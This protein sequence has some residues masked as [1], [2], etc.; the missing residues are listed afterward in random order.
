MTPDVRPDPPSAPA[1][2]QAWSRIAREVIGTAYPWVPGHT[3]TGPDDAHLV[4]EVLHPAFHGSLD[5]HSCVHM[6]WSLLTLLSRYG[7]ALGKEE[8]RAVRGLLG[9]RLRPEQVAVEVDYLRERPGFERPYGWAWAAQLCAA[10][11][12]AGEDDAEVAGWAAATGPLAE[13]V[14]DLVLGWLPRQPYPVR[15]GKHQNDAFALWLL[16]DAFERL[17]RDG[18]VEAC[19]GRSLDWFGD[20]RGAPTGW[21]PGG[22]DFLSPALTEAGLMTRVLPQ[23]R[24][25]PWLE[26]FLPGLGLAGDHDPHRHLLEVPVV[27][28]PTDGQYAHLL[29][30]ALSRA[31]QL[32]ELTPHLDEVR[33]ERLRAAAVEQEAAVLR[34][35]T[36]GDFMATHWLVSFALLAHGG[37]A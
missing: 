7:D 13:I 32:R 6:Q 31:W 27:L 26:A 5:W 17:G 21:E 15:H 29:G 23:D 28:D 14:G 10:L 12:E 34:E 30:L 11:A 37:L 36:E 4:P 25:R 2:A 22:T 3:V 24:V 35:I 9:E 1:D 19:W 33:A 8:A 20:D 16:L 18:V